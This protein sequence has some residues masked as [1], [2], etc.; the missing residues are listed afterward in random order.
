MNLKYDGNEIEVA[1]DRVLTLIGS[2]N[3][4]SARAIINGMKRMAAQN[5]P[6]ALVINSSGGD[7]E[8]VLAIADAQRMWR[9]KLV[10]IGMGTV[11]SAALFLLQIGDIRLATRNAELMLHRGT[12][13]SKERDPDDHEAFLRI[14]RERDRKFLRLLSARSHQSKGKIAQDWLSDCYYTPRQAFNYGLID[15]IIQLQ[16][17]RPMILTLSARSKPSKRSTRS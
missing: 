13:D 2:I 4:S 17:R 12:L 3:T 14:C 16:K 6:L 15:G 11:Y 8:Q 1:D 9:L 5:S 10:T 7:T